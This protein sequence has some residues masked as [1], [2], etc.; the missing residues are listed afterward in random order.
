[1]ARPRYLLEHSMTGALKTEEIMFEG[2][3][4]LLHLV[5]AIWAILS[6]LKSGASGLAK[7]LWALAV[8]IF[9]IV[10]LIIWF[11]AGPKG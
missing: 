7:V 3:L 6:I 8:L 9:P 2:L 4:G 5:I 10:G 1:M 11:I